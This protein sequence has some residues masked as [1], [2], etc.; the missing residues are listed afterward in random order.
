MY[1]T[2]QLKHTV[3]NKVHSE[4][5]I[6]VLLRGKLKVS[7]S[8]RLVRSYLWSHNIYHNILLSKT[9]TVIHIIP[10]NRLQ[11]L[12]GLYSIA[13]ATM[14]ATWAL[15]S[16]IHHQEE[17]YIMLAGCALDSINNNTVNF[18]FKKKKRFLPRGPSF[19]SQERPDTGRCML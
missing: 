15:R 6:Q 14:T 16:H 2:S 5:T 1:C 10:V 17:S 13:Q 4:T 7:P 9:Y 19:V 8:I 3:T 12:L 11:G 18:P